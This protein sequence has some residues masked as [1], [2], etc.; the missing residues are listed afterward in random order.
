MKRS[1]LLFTGIILILSLILSA[2]CSS[3]KETVTSM[4]PAVVITSTTVSTATATATNP[5]TTLKLMSVKIDQTSPPSLYVDSTQTF[6]ATGIYSDS[7]TNK[8]YSATWVSDNP[9]VATID[10]FGVATGVAPGKTNIT[11]TQFGI[12]SAPV[13][14]TVIA[15]PTTPGA[16]TPAAQ[17]VYVSVSVDGKLLVAAQPVAYTKDMTLE[18]VVKAAHTAYYADG[19][20]GYQ[21][22]ESAFGAGYYIINK[23]WGVQSI[24]CIIVNDHINSEVVFQAVNAVKVS[25]NDNII[26]CTVKSGGTLT[27]VS[28]TATIA[29]GKVTV[30]AKIWAQNASD[31]TWSNKPDKGANVLDSK[32]TVLGKTDDNGQIT[33]DIPA[34]GVVIIEGFAAINVNASAK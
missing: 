5:V 18:A 16:T 22:D 27:P 9:A 17:K 6:T 1:L 15:V 25:A 21:A 2:G 13:S 34:D 11:A 29:G 12:K 3:T 30:T 19:L 31:Y 32:G 10:G 24:P 20:K 4:A 33:I 23:C 26:I 7:S 28:L 8:L 14:L